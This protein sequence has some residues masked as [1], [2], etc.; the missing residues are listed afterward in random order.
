MCV[1][2]AEIDILR[3]ARINDKLGVT[4]G[5]ADRAIFYR[6]KYR[7]KKL[8]EKNGLPIP[9]MS[10]IT[11]ALDLW[12]FAKHVGYP[13]V[14]KPRDGRG[15]NGVEVIRD[16]KSLKHYLNQLV[17]TSFYNLMAEKYVVGDHY[18]VNGLYI[19]HTPV[20]ISPVKVMTSALDFL[21]GK[22]HDLS[23]L[24]KENPIR[25]KLVAY[26]RNLIENVMPSE[27]TTLFHLEAF[28]DVN[29]DIII[30]EI[31]SRLGG[32][33]FNQELTHAWGLDPRMTYLAA[34]ANKG[35]KIDPM[36]EPEQLVG[37]ISIPPSEGYLYDAPSKCLLN[38]VLEY[39]LSAKKGSSYGSMEYTN[40]EIFNAIV[41]G[42]TEKKIA[43][44][45]QAVEKWFRSSCVWS[46]DTEIAAS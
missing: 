43:E 26:S 13:I 21:K 36:Q 28:V 10:E 34:M 25:D 24:D 40:S 31:A 35:Y 19:D 29:G 17:N 9:E 4:E 20:L 16:D 27:A 42:G 11:C 23:M 30:C 37:H 46:T 33:F 2:L 41:G 39:R 5:A 38:E 44:N 22:S 6:D 8:V 14:V 15:S 32:V 12:S 3:V 18:I 1:A 7:M 45:L